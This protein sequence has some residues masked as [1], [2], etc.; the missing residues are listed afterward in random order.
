MPRALLKMLIKNILFIGSRI[1]YKKTL[2][3]D[4]GASAQSHV[5]NTS[6]VGINR[7]QKVLPSYE[8]LNS[9]GFYSSGNSAS[10]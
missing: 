7:M 9:I 3:H 4:I 5:L 6:M 8:Y 10:F 2:I 1:R